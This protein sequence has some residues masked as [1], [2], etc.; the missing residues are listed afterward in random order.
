M[1]RI[2]FLTAMT[3]FLELPLALAIS[4]P[5][6]FNDPSLTLPARADLRFAASVVSTGDFVTRKREERR[7]CRRSAQ[8]GSLAPAAGNMGDQLGTFLESPRYLRTLEQM[9]E[10]GLLEARVARQPWSGDYW[11]IA[12]GI[13]GAR[14]FE[15]GF[16]IQP[17]WH[18][19]YL[20]VQRFSAQ[21]VLRQ[22]GADILQKLSPSEKYDLIIGD[23]SGAM[24]ASMWEQGREY[25]DRTGEVES[26]MG[27]CHGWAPAAIADPRP[28]SSV[29]VSSLDGKWQVPL[30]PAE[31]K[32]LVS[33]SWATNR[34]NS[35]MLGSRC[36]KKNPKRDANGRMI[37]PDCFDLN[38]ATWH[39]AV[40]NKVGLKKESFVMDATY[41]YEVWNQPVLGYSYSYF[42]PETG[43][44]GDLAAS[45]IAADAF[46][47]DPY[48]AYRSAEVASIVGVRMKIGYVLETSVSDDA[49]DDEAQDIVRWVEYKYDLE[50]DAKNRIIGGEWRLEAHPD[51]IW[52]PRSG[53]RPQS[54]LDSALAGE[55]WE[56][57]A[58]VPAK[59]A[60][61]AK[62]GAAR[63]LI[64]D[65]LTA[66]LL[67]KSATPVATPSLK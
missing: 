17:N 32:G 29:A 57:D 27:I 8:D 10:Q 36:T 63:G 41:D 20:Y 16:K 67:K 6:K 3:A 30:T 28:A 40:V 31:I 62:Y 49:N 13:L 52:I 21:D 4:I 25:Y 65:T 26:W 53:F 46:V 61:A 12:R 1:R 9:E 2:L 38:P 56:E 64:L 47:D 45:T 35:L 37:D 60:K 34:Y 15:L 33:Y 5:P 43:V 58:P 22:H 50:L 59:W 23:E 42:N 14:N 19:R 39:I 44:P 55:R 7:A 11:A 24:T 51:F 54:P 66:A 18:E 48:R